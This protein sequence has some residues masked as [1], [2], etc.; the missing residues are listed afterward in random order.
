MDLTTGAT[1][2]AREVLEHFRNGTR[3]QDTG[4]DTQPPS[5]GTQEVLEAYFA[6][7]WC[8]EPILIGRRSLTNQQ[9][10]ND[11]GPAVTFLDDLL[12]WHLKGWAERWPAVRAALKA[13]GRVPNLRDHDSLC[14]FCD[15]VEQVT[16]P[17]EHTAQIRSLI[18]EEEEGGIGVN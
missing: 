4:P 13:P 5:A 11:T 1:A 7:L 15:L 16:G 14:S 9:D 17:N 10:W 18:R 6:L 8:F 2:Q 12:A 3:Y